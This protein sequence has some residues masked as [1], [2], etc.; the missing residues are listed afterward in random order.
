MPT[1]KS[2]LLATDLS[3][4]CDR[5]LDRSVELA[6]AWHARVV[7]MHALETPVP[8][9]DAPSWQGQPDLR[10]IAARRIR[11]D[12]R[13][14]SAIDLELVVERGAAA[15]LVLDTAARLGCELIVTGVAR[16]ETLGR[17]LVGKTV[18]DVI[19]RSDVPVLVAKSRPRGPYRRIVVA[20]DFSESSR[21]ALVTA[22]SMFE[23][24]SISL[25]H[26]FDV[27][28]EGLLHDRMAVREGFARQARGEAEA[29]LASTPLPRGRDVPVVCEYGSPAALLRDL[30]HS[31]D[32]DLIAAG[33]QGRGRA[34]EL[35]LGSVAKALVE[36]V[37]SDVLIVPRAR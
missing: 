2:I 7:V 16:D 4:R 24:A 8:V 17:T 9:I 33:T 35:F 10:S 30:V 15:P 26:A 19:R 5:A 34:A 1:P 12:L 18:E 23:D 31:S 14:A 21:R 6:K 28:Y 25:F 3:S 13:D 22:L 32:V 36:G 29:F 11:A 37:P 27:P 20:S